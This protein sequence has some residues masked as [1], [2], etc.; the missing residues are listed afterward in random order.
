MLMP[1]INEEQPYFSIIAGDLNGIF[2]NWWSQYI[3]NSQGSMIGTFTSTSG[4]QQII[5]S[6]TH[7]AYTNSSCTDLI[8]TS[9]LTTEF[10]VEKVLYTD[11][12]HHSIVFG[13]MNLNNP[14]P[15]PNTQEVW[16]YN[17]AYRKNIP[18]SIKTC[19]WS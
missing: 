14:L 9:D 17:K 16:D 11:S 5:N 4:Y 8:F 2:K 3:T 6:S 10:G 15:P 12:C 19:N 18:R 13:K 7:M 1:N